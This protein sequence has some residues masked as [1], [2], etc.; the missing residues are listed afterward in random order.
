MSFNE[1]QTSVSLLNIQNKIIDDVK[2]ELW[3]VP[4]VRLCFQATYRGIKLSSIDKIP[5]DTDRENP[6]IFNKIEGKIHFY[7]FFY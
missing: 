6:I 4:L 7:M 3:N 1:Q 5:L 2:K